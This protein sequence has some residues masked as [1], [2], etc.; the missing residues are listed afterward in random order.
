MHGKG[1]FRVNMKQSRMTQLLIKSPL[2]YTP[3]VFILMSFNL[4]CLYALN[5]GV[6]IVS[7]GKS[8]VFFFFFFFNKMNKWLRHVKKYYTVVPDLQ[9]DNIIIGGGVVGLALGEKLT[10]E[11]PTETTFVVEKNKLI[12]QE[13]RLIYIVR[14]NRI[15]QTKQD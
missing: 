14:S 9:V 4:I 12:G 2:S 3:V 11:R 15:H 6:T 10:R 5:T 7:S 13:T 8:F 1:T